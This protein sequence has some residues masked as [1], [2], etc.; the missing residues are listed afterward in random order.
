[1]PLIILNVAEKIILKITKT[2]LK[3]SIKKSVL[4]TGLGLSSFPVMGEPPM[5]HRYDGIKGNTQGEKNE[6]KPALRAT[7]KDISCLYLTR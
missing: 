6:K 2:A 1:M 5:I 3:P 4:A 7:K